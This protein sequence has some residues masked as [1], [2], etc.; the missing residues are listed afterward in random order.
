M[1]Q[2]HIR[3]HTDFLDKKVTIVEGEGWFGMVEF[4]C[5]AIA[6]I[7]IGEIADSMLR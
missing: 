3:I 6:K 7:C 2:R 1:R 4:K 5:L